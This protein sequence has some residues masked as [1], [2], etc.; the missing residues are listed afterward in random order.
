MPRWLTIITYMLAL[1]FL[2]F[3]NTVREARFLFYG[4]V[5]LVSA[6]ILILNYRRRQDQEG[7]YELSMDA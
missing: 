5:L 6:Y 3:A 1:G 7:E 4:W 2:L